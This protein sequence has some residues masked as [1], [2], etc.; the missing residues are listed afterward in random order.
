MAIREPETMLE[1]MEDLEFPAYLHER[2]LRCVRQA[3]ARQARLKAAVS[4][5][6]AVASFAALG[7]ISWY[8]LQ[9]ARASGFLSYASLVFSDTAAVFALRGDFIPLLV[10]TFPFVFV[11][12]AAGVAVVCFACVRMAREHMRNSVSRVSVA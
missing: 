5:T 10:E 4:F 2:I 6:A 12:L 9:A 1:N 8:A 11:S 3:A 7:G